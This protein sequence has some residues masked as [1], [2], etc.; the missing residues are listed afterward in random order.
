MEEERTEEVVVEEDKKTEDEGPTAFDLI[1]DR[2][3]SIE[4][5][6]TPKVEETKEEDKNLGFDPS[7]IVEESGKAGQQ[8]FLTLRRVEAELRKEFAGELQDEQLEEILGTL[9]GMPI[10]QLND[11]VKG[12]GHMAMGYAHIGAAYKKGKLKTNTTKTAVTPIGEESPRGDSEASGMLD[13]FKQ[14]YGEPNEAQKK[15]LLG[16]MGG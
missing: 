10:G 2:F 16:Y 5:R 7:R 4:E 11:T 9:A 14:M 8:G 13:K 3:K 1:M 15:R 6:L 12:K